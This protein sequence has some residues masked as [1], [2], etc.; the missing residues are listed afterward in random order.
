MAQL[1]EQHAQEEK[2]DEQDALDRGRPAAV[3]VM[4]HRQPCQKDQER[5]VDL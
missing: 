4:G 1:M 5:E 2:H 3:L